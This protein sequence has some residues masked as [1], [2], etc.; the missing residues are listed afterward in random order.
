M[1]RS[2]ACI[3][4]PKRHRQIKVRI[5]RETHSEE[6]NFLYAILPIFRHYKFTVQAKTIRD[7]NPKTNPFLRQLSLILE[8]LS[9]IADPEEANRVWE[10]KLASSFKKNIVWFNKKEE[11]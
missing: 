2:G 7:E 9:K 10:K 8:Q 11:K 4:R 1:C 6:E 3:P 5:N